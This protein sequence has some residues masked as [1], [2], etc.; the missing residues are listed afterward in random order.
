MHLFHVF[1][2]FIFVLLLHEKSG[3]IRQFFLL[4][5]GFRYGKS[6]FDSCS[7]GVFCLYTTNLI[8]R[9]S[10]VMARIINVP[11]D[12]IRKCSTDKLH[13][14]CLALA[15][16]LKRT[17]VNST[18]YGVNTKNFRRTF[19]ISYTKAQKMIEAVKGSELF[20]YNEEHD[21]LFAKSFKSK[22]NKQYGRKGQYIAKADYCKKISECADSLRDV[23]RLLRETLLVVEIDAQTWESLCGHAQK[24]SHREAAK[25]KTPIPLRKFA[26]SISM[27]RA[28]TSR[29]ISRMEKDGK[30]SKSEIVAECVLPYYTSEK[31]GEWMV[32]HPNQKLH[33]WYSEKYHQFSAWINFGRK[34]SVTDRKLEDSFQHVIYNH[35]KRISTTNRKNQGNEDTRP[36]LFHG[37]PR[38]A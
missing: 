15:V 7:A 2:L 36:D 25:E 14:E 12:L 20:E 3:H 35:A 9:N 8:T 37:G 17:F 38:N 11:L 22:D 27:S 10:F 29:Y 1:F 5:R 6:L 4:A 33:V 16:M 28:S 34:Y 24:H 32:R 18:L 21:F 19:H 30:V 26:K 13:L 31:A 23:T